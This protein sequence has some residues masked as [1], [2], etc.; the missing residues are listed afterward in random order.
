FI[1]DDRANALDWTN[2]LD[3]SKD[4]KIIP[5]GDLDAKRYVFTYASDQDYYNKLYQDEFKE[6]YGT[7]TVNINSDFVQNEKRIE[8]VF[9][10]TPIASAADV[11]T[12]GQNVD[13]VMPRLYA[14]IDDAKPMKCKIRRL[15]WGGMIDCTNHILY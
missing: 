7:Q 1:D 6:V 8:L 4:F 9:A 13:L 3:R 11:T 12:N 2:K 15:Y 14:D 5:M 10:A